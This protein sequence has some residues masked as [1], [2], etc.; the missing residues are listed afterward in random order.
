MSFPCQEKHLF[1]LSPLLLFSLSLTLQYSQLF[2]TNL[3]YC[4]KWPFSTWPWDF[5][6]TPISHVYNNHILQTTKPH[7]ARTVSYYLGLELHLFDA[8][9]TMHKL[10]LYMHACRCAY[11]GSNHRPRQF[12]QHIFS[13][14]RNL[15][16]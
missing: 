15:N 14:H 2:P 10:T 11:L 12:L 6:Q 16:P 3:M 4:R 13:V 5:L 1:N 7:S 9:A 8:Q